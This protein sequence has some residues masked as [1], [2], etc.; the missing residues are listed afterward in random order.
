MGKSRMKTNNAIFSSSVHLILTQ[1][2]LTFTCDN[3]SCNTKLYELLYS[4]LTANQNR[5]I[6][7]DIKAAY[8]L[9]SAQQH[10]KILH[11]THV[12][13]QHGGSYSCMRYESFMQRSLPVKNNRAES[14]GPQHLAV[15]SSRLTAL[16]C[17][18]Q[19]DICHCSLRETRLQQIIGPL[20]T[21]LSLPLQ[22]MSM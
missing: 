19:S 14:C 6:P 7:T 8:K 5:K 9:F 3:Q 17:P 4:R 16:R 22:G 10:L 21:V 20:E 12:V 18:L 11:N 2:C 13:T 1:Q 15:R